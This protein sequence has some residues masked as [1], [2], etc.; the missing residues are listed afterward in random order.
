MLK[1]TKCGTDVQY[2][3]FWLGGKLKCNHCGQNLSLEFRSRMIPL[4]LYLVPVAFLMWKTKGFP[5]LACLMALAFFSGV[6]VLLHN[7]RWLVRAVPVD[8]GD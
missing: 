2:G 8:K 3:R 4:L 5:V 7:V 6:D 1:C